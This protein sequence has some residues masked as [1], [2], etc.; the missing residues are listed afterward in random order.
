MI[1]TATASTKKRLV[2]PNIGKLRDDF[3]NGGLSVFM[4]TLT[5]EHIIFKPWPSFVSGCKASF[6]MAYTDDEI[7]LKYYV[8]ENHL[9]ALF[10]QTNATVYKDS[11][12]EFFIAFEHERGYYNLEFNCLGVAKIA[13]GKSRT[14]R[15]LLPENI[16]EQITRCTSLKSVSLGNHSDFYWEIMLII[17]NQVFSHHNI[18]SLKGINCRANFYKCGDDLLD[19]HFLSWNNIRAPNPDFHLPEFFGEIYFNGQSNR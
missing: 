15:T 2:I 5:R 14:N 6:S 11:C 18:A 3:T 12:V 13:F 10:H 1:D 4:D 9:R 19:P 8:T 7:I 17:P 16:V